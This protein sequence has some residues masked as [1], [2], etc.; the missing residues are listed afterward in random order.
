MVF[1]SIYKGNINKNLKTS[2]KTYF[3]YFKSLKFGFSV[4]KIDICD[5][6]TEC[7]QKLKVN[8]KDFCQIEYIL[9]QKKVENLKS[10][11]ISHV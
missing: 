9:H 3:N 7:S 4:P 5:F 10:S 8:T 11:I 6:C 1:K 2:Y